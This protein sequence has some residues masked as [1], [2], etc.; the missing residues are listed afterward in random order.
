MK[1]MH[2][3]YQTVAR[4]IGYLR[5]HRD[6][7]PS[8]EEVSRYVHVSKF[9]LQ[10]TFREWAGVSPK[11]FLGFLTV[12]RSKE[13]LLAGQSTLAAAYEVGLS[14]NGRLHDLFVKYEACSP[15]EFKRGGKG[16]ELQWGVVATAFGPALVA[17]SRRG[18]CKVAFI[19]DEASANTALRVEYPEARLTAGLGPNAER[20]A[21][22]FADWTIPTEQIRLHFPGTPFQLQVWKALLRVPVGQVVAYQDIGRQIGKP[23][24]VRAVG[25]AVGKNP[26]A[27][28]IPCHR[29]IKSD[30]S[31]GNYRW[32][33]ERKL[34]MNAYEQV[35]FSSAHA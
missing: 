5:E 34:I 14:G 15:G 25:T 12:E 30:G 10:R 6:G 3:H 4:A 2:H 17:E 27:Y 1:I 19:D 8:L 22:Y 33:P 32:Q 28:L 18:L 31:S 9:H 26:I 24:A 20:L 23:R 13:L 21:R 29:V 11:D 35:K 7:Q 16:L